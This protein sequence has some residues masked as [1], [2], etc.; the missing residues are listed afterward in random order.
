VPSP[1][2]IAAVWALALALS[3]C[4]APEA[5]EPV[6]EA[7]LPA[8]PGGARQGRSESARQ[9]VDALLAAPSPAALLAVLGQ[10]HGV[11][12]ELL[13]KHTLRYTA[14]FKLAP[15][16]ASKPVVD[17]PIA[18]A[19]EVRD[20]L[21]LRWAAGPGEPARFFLSQKTDKN[22]GRELVVIDEQVY[23]K[24]MHR[25]W[26]ARPLDGDVH[27]RWLDEAQRSVH[28]AVAFAAPALAVTATE[29]GDVVRVE[30]AR[31]AAVDPGLVA[32]GAGQAWRQ[33]AELTEVS[34]SV[35]LQ[36][37]TGL[38]QSAEVHVRYTAVDEQ[39]RRML[40]ETHLTGEVEATADLQ[41]S[42]PEGAQPLP[43]R[44]RYEAERRRLLG[45]L[46]GT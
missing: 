37:A 45:G 32:A 27:L 28:D 17:Q 8:R 18:A 2:R 3:S 5:D 34:G 29:E 6:A 41:V 44:V 38:W 30:L 22:R 21:E 4:G 19:Q 31:A 13:G 14:D 9:A 40:G 39:G 1:P 16:T 15:E 26:H 36:R 43:E 10:G 20:E 23:T 33:R 7:R 42:A 12:R 24:L 35:T 11:A 25:G 46:A